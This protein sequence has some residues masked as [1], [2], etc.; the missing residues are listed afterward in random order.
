MAVP[1]TTPKKPVRDMR[2]DVLRGWMQVSIFISHAFASVFAW[3]I[4]ASWGFSDSSEQFMLLSGITLGSVFTLKRVR[5]GFAAAWRDMAGR[6]ARLWRM[7]MVVFLA[8]GTMVFL[9]ERLGGLQGEVDI[10]GWHWLRD[11]P[12][13]AIPGAAAM[14][15]QPAFMD[16]LPV[17]IWCMLLLPLFVWLLERFGDV[18]LALPA[19]LYVAAQTGVAIPGLGGWPLGFHP[20]AWQ[21]LF[22]LGIWLGRRALLGAAPLPRPRA[23]TYAA[24]AVLALGVWLRAGQMG[25][26]PEAPE[27]LVALSEK[28][29]LAPLRLL[30]ALALAWVVVAIIPREGAWLQSWPAQVM[31]TIGRNSLNVFCLGLF[32]SWIC[33]AVFR[34]F[35]ENKLLLDLAM[36]PTGIALLWLMA[37]WSGRP[38][39]PARSGYRLATA[40][41]Q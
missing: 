21:V 8:F 35:P 26:L 19:A 41:S 40:R 14:L 7:H 3:V 32:L 25:L 34:S 11:E 17:F 30:H 1:G 16:I 39:G 20:L 33:F 28:P 6:A 9:G 24:V 5:D 36:I 23:V 4:H 38:K 10:L 22:M 18:A 13:L 29:S 2:L 15:Y 37:W 27:M 12:W 31:A